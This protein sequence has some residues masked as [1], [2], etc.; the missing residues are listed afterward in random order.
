[1]E[2]SKFQQ[3]VWG[4]ATVLGPLCLSISQFFWQDGLVTVNG[5]LAQVFA[6]VFY[7]L[8]FQ[9]MFNS[10][11]SSMPRYAALG[12][13]IATY[14]CFAGNNFGVEGIYA[15]V[16]GCTD[17]EAYRA[18]QALVG[19]VSNWYLFLPGIL[20]PFSLLAIGF[21]LWRKN[22]VSLVAGGLTMLGAIGFPLS[23]IPRIE[24][25]AHIDNLIL[26]LAG[27]LVAYELYLKENPKA[28]EEA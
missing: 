3:N 21:F 6:F 23:R 2:N 20:F 15:A 27:I 9:G 14:A 5:G 16:A 19:P 8:A 24:L 22:K 1:M 28:P 7:L 12:F 13:I 11:K 26:L 18:W 10:L 25:I 4:A 17:I